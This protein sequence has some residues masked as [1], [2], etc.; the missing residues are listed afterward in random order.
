VKDPERAATWLFRARAA[1]PAIEVPEERQK[2]EAAVQ[3]S[4]ASC[5]QLKRQQQQQRVK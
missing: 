3:Q 4:L 5:E 2:M 1:L